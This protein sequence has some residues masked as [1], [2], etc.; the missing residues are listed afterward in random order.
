[1]GRNTLP[2]NSS[3]DPTIENLKYKIQNRNRWSRREFLTTA[4]LA[5]TGA[6]LGWRPGA[7]AAEPP[8]ETTSLR[9]LESP[10]LCWAPQYVAEELLRAEGFSRLEYVKKQIGAGIFQALASGEAHMSMSIA[11]PLIIKVDGVNPII[12]LAGV[13]VGCYQLFGTPRVRTI[14]DL[15]GK[16]VGVQGLGGGAHVTL[17]TMLSYVG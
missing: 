14:R 7:V 1:M 17:S 5:G 16:T 8:P 2:I 13:H 4:A 9:L 6:L 12:I 15:K 10:A 3:L 11:G